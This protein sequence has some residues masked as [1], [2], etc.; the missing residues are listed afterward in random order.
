RASDLF[1]LAEHGG[2]L[3]AG[4]SRLNLKRALV[5]GVQS[6]ILF[7]LHQQRELANGMAEVV[8]SVKFTPLDSVKGHDSFLVDMDAFRPVICDYFETCGLAPQAAARTAV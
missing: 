8:E 5:I 4:F 7:P 3:K 6:D 1:D 2:S